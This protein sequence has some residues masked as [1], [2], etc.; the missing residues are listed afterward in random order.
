MKSKTFYLLT[1]AIAAIVIFAGCSRSESEDEET[2]TFSIAVFVPGM[3][4]GSPTYE[5]LVAGVQKAAEESDRTEVKVVEGGFN[6]AEWGDQITSLAAS[7]SWDLI[8]SSNPSLP[9]LC[10]EVSE[11]FPEQKFLL[12]DGYIDGNDSIHSV[13]FNHKEQGYLN[14]YFGGLITVSSLPHANPALRAGLLA[15]QEYPVMNKV[16]IPG[17]ELGLKA[18]NPDIEL[19]IRILGNWYDATKASDLAASMI[20][21]EVDVI[22]TIAG[23]GNQGVVSAAEEKSAYVLW[24]DSSGYHY[25][26]GTVLGSSLVRLDKAAYERTKAAV[27]GELRYGE[28]ETLGVREGYIGFDTESE[29]YTDH[30]PR[31]I[32]EKMT[33]L[34]KKM[35]SGEVHLKMPNL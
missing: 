31:E 5:M 17:Y 4:E 22:L 19:D 2:G 27:A 3:T 21:N 35:E 26:P 23:G 7:G 9:E 25:A 11:E 18:V 1:A 10:S 16:I 13:L 32:R 14:G 20:D 24:F 6:Q 29:S 8:V 33:D 15:G 34:I 28:A 12:L 30:V